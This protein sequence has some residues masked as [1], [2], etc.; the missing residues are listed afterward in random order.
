MPP[1]RWFLIGPKRSGSEIHQDPLGTSAWNTS[2]QGHK[3]WI[4]IPPGAGLTKKYARGKHLMRKGEDDEA[5]H[6]FD[7]IWPRLKQSER[8]KPQE[9]RKF[10]EV[11]ECIQYPGETM[12]V[13]GGWWH[14][15]INLDLT[16][17]ITENVCN[18]GNFERVW[19]QTRKSRKHLAFKWLRLL[20]RFK[21][22]MYERAKLLNVRDDFEMWVP[23]DRKEREGSSES[24]ESSSDS[25]S[26][27]SSSSS[28]TSSDDEL[29]IETIRRDLKD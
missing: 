29:S 24:S 8:E 4:L 14:A 26:S 12:F 6:Y 13:P 3:R 5:I 27:S 11:I 19:T 17:A 23:P 21:P 10:K 9:E 20:K 7:F 1:H 25:S 16:I 15:V 2:I 18:E 28:D 22:K